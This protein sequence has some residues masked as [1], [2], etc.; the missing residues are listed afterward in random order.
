M[1]RNVAGLVIV[2]VGAAVVQLAVSNTY[3]RYVKPG[4]R[5]MLL[6]AGI[7]LIALAVADVLA[8]TRKKDE[9]DHGLAD[10]GH[11]HH[12]L[13][14]AAWLLLIPIFALLV[15]DPPALGAAAAE[16]QSPVAS[17]PIQPKSN[18][19]LADNPSGGPVQ[20]P[21]RDYSVWAVWEKESMKG[22]SFELSGFVTPGKN[23]SWYITRM[24]L[25]CCVADATAF[26]VEA[27]GQSTAPAKNQW[28]KVTGEWAEPTKRADGDVAAL[29]VT[30]VSPIPTPA[31]QYE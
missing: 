12:G 29:T 7:I 8:D 22:R 24:G 23:G 26:M 27:R 6:A 11:G 25:N 15:V 20:L 13:P 18:S 3:L 2:F 30:S 19:W 21:V 10:D 16:R 4:M 5:W 31:N 9:H 17:K 14:R 1:K 28:V